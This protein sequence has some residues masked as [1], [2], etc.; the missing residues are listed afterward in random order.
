MQSRNRL[1]EG[2]RGFADRG[3]VIS[4]DRPPEPLHRRVHRGMVL[5]TRSDAFPDAI[6]CGDTGRNQTWIL[7]FDIDRKLACP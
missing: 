6:Q 5:Q 4:V 2:G 1:I 3:N 7:G